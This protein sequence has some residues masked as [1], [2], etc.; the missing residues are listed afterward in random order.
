MT[1]GKSCHITE[2]GHLHRRR[3]V[4]FS[5]V[6]QSLF[7][8]SKGAV[9]NMGTELAQRFEIVQQTFDEAEHIFQ[10]EVENFPEIV[11]RRQCQH[12]FKEREAQL[13]DTRIAQPATLAMI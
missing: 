5:K 6:R 9:F 4:D 2:E 7:V 12:E 10:K 3:D 8:Y 11:H 13:K 1:K